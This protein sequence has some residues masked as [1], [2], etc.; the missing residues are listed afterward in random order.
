MRAHNEGSV[1]PEGDHWRAAISVPGGRIVRRRAKSKAEAVRKLAELK[2][3]R[4]GGADPSDRSTLGS[5]LRRW[6]DDVRPRMAPATWKK[7]ES[8]CRTGLVPSLGY[9]R[10]SEL[11]VGD[12]RT[13]LA[14]PRPSRR[15]RA[16]MVRH[17]GQTLRHHRATLRRA[18]ADAQREGL[19]TR[20]VAALAEPPKL[21]EKER[22]FLTAEQVR[23]L[24]EGTRECRMHAFW[25]LAA[26]TGMREAELLGL[27][28]RDVA[29][30]RL[31][32][33]WSGVLWVRHT[34]QRID[35]EWRMTEPK[36]VKS[37]RVIPLTQVAVAAL[38]AHV[39]R[40]TAEGG[41]YALVFTTPKG[42]PVHGTNLLP[43]LYSHE[44]R[45]GLPRVGIHGLRHSA[46][47]VMH[48][49]GVPLEVISDILGHSTVRVTA[50]LYR[51]RVPEL[52]SEAARRM[53]EAIGG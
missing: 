48:A 30:E 34:L 39:D 28:W 22:P 49:A 17:S 25:T 52:A 1:Y 3:L 51:H 42:Q 21:A 10:L 23:T 13:Y 43:L 24:L 11:S 6:L 53:Q 47:T 9:R 31:A 4:D 27:A 40:Q 12:V 35:G 5:Y 46:A 18:L 37:K 8:I 50:D 19:V 7:H 2:R 41:P 16:G 14:E 20:N 26:T 15:T 29:L 36:T 45:L 38:L 33:G 44:E 32:D